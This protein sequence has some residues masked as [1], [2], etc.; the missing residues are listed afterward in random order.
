MKRARQGNPY[1]QVKYQGLFG[2]IEEI[3]EYH[4]YSKR[5]LVQKGWIIDASGEN[6]R[7]IIDIERGVDSEKFYYHIQ[8]EDLNECGELIGARSG[9]GD[10]D[11]VQKLI[12][13]AITN[14]IDKETFDGDYESYW[15]EKV[16]EEFTQAVF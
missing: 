6:T 10:F 13:E 3:K 5:R 4:Y 16:L 15:Y 12:E 14:G 9:F 1:Q 8:F 7:C 11:Y 2:N